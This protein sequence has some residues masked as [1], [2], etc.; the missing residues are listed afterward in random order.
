MALSLHK[1]KIHVPFPSAPAETTLVDLSFKWPQSMM[2]AAVVRYKE[3]ENLIVKCEN[4]IR[5][6][7][8]GSK[9]V[10]KFLE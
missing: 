10:I 9:S 2:L 4:S 3:D 6:R 5:F 8:I 7:A 1:A